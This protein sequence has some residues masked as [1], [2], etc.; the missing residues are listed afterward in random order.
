MADLSEKRTAI[1]D[2]SLDRIYE[3]AF[4]PSA[5][6]NVAA[7]VASAM[8]ATNGIVII[9]RNGLPIDQ[10]ATISSQAQADYFRH[11]GRI[12]VWTPPTMEAPP[13]TIMRSE[14]QIDDDDV[15]NSEFYH[16]Y[17]RHL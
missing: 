14:R 1:V 6:A 8:Q 15:L 9:T 7:V 12:D 16:D 13:Y 4:D 3:A 2:Q 11:Y 17:A 10:S 5:F